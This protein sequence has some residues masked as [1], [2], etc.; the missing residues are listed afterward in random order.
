MRGSRVKFSEL[1]GSRAAIAG[2]TL[3]VYTDL[4]NCADKLD[5]LGSYHSSDAAPLGTLA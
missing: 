2:A 3:A 1:A 4:Y 5:G